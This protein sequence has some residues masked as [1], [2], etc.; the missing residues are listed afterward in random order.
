M[1]QSDKVRHPYKVTIAMTIDVWA[2]D[3]NDAENLAWDALIDDGAPH[4][5]LEVLGFDAE[6][7]SSVGEY[8]FCP[9]NDESEG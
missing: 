2:V 9:I 7:V 6:L 4:W 1:E 8:N 3:A 5:I